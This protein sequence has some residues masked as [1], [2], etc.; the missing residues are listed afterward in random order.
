MLHATKLSQTCQTPRYSCKM[1]YRKVSGASL[2][3]KRPALR[4]AVGSAALFLPAHHKDVFLFRML[5]ATV[6][7]TTAMAQAKC[8][9]RKS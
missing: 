8:L 6:A 3:T 9:C 5:H 4:E 1:A 2:V 7:D